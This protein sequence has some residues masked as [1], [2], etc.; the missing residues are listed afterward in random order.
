[1]CNDCIAI[2]LGL[3]YLMM[4]GQVEPDNH[5]DAALRCRQDKV[6]CHG[7][8]IMLVRKHKSTFQR[9]EDKR[10][11]DNKDVLTL[12]KRLPYN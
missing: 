1:M 2:A 6:T 12:D 5:F 10:I 3:P 4:L 9:K 8:S 11:K 7:Y